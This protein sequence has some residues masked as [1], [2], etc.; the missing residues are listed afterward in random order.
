MNTTELLV[1]LQA[2]G[3]TLSA[4]NGN[5]RISAPR[6]VLTPELRQRLA[7]C[8]AELLNRLPEKEATQAPRLPPTTALGASYKTVAEQELDAAWEHW[9]AMEALLTKEAADNDA[10]DV[11][12]QSKLIQ[13]R[14]QAAQAERAFYDAEKEYVAS[15]PEQPAEK[16]RMLPSNEAVHYWLSKEMELLNWFGEDLS[17]LQERNQRGKPEPGDEVVL[18]SLAATTNVVLHGEGGEALERYLQFFEE[19]KQ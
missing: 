3:I 16:L 8:K 17:A 15:L 18:K 6:N 10:S 11:E 14:L 12:V 7:E 9:H 5:L 4:D 13:L 2:R 1:E 19:A